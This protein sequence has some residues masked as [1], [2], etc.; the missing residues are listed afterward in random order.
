MLAPRIRLRD[1]ALDLRPVRSGKVGDS[2]QPGGNLG[3]G[4]GLHYGTQ[5]EFPPLGELNPPHKYPEP[6][7]LD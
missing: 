7:Y 3:L 6:P 5:G 4:R 1:T 2:F